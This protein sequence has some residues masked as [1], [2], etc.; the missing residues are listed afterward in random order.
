MRHF[1]KI[2]FRTG[3]TLELF[4]EKKSRPPLESSYIYIFL[5][6]LAYGLADIWTS[7]WRSYMFP[8][9]SGLPKRALRLR[10]DS[11]T[12]T[13]LAPLILDHNIFNADHFIP[14][15]LGDKNQDKSPESFPPV[16]S[17]LPLNLVGT[18]VHKRD[19]FSVC[20]IQIRGKNK[21]FPY[22]VGEKVDNFAKVHSIQRGKVIFLNLNSQRLEYIEIVDKTP[23]EL[24]LGSSNKEPTKGQSSEDF[25][26]DRSEVDTYLENLPKLL[27]DAKAIPHIP[28]GSGGKVQGFKLVGIRSGSVYEKL[29]LKKGDIIKS[30]NGELVDSPQRAIQLYQT[31][32]NTDSIELGLIREGSEKT[33]NY[34]IQ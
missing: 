26:F 19:I 9:T 13:S 27:Q 7:S 10:R 23:I 28:P 14:S 1:K 20:T 11:V 34:S 3:H 31:L 22:K 16:P 15:S 12:P 32:K 33:F 25:N 18:I 5:F 4:L 21:I 8:Q 29:G 24:S 2:L 6:L 30:V 17:Q